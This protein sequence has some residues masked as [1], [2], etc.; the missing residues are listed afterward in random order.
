QIK[1]HSMNQRREHAEVAY[2]G[3]S[4]R[5]YV[6]IARPDHW[7]KNVFMIPGAAFALAA[8]PGAIYTRA[9]PLGLAVV[10]LCLVASANYTIN[11]FLDSEYDRFHP[12]KSTRAGARRLVDCRFVL[13]QLLVLVLGGCVLAWLI[14]PLYLLTSVCLLVMGLIYNVPPVRTKDKIYLDVISESINNPLRFM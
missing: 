9:L 1:R 14:S 5:E 4:L 3:G 7:I 11:E 2:S 10:S 13:L 12:V 8:T 6:S